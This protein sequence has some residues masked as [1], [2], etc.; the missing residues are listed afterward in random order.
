MTSLTTI[1]GLIPMALNEETG[2]GLSY[3]VLARAVCGGLLTSTFFTLWIVPLCY[4]LF[5]DLSEAVRNTFRA[6]L[7]PLLRRQ[8]A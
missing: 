7:A 5:D 3:K 1:V 8:P 6:A 2:D 4:S